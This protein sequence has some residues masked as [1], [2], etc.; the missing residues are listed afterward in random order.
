MSFL[1][2]VFIYTS[3]GID[4]RTAAFTSRE[5]CEQ[6]KV[7]VLTHMEKHV[8]RGKEVATCVPQ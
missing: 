2:F 1:L 5:T 6:A 8:V 7:L 4:V 3:S